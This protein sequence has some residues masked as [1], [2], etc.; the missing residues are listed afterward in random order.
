[1]NGNKTGMLIVSVLLPIIGMFL[2]INA[3]TSEGNVVAN[4]AKFLMFG[5]LIIG[6]IRPK[7]AIHLMI[8]ATGYLDL[9]KR[10]MIMDIT[11][12]FEDLYYVLGIAPCLMAGMIL[13]YLQKNMRS[14]VLS[15]GDLIRFVG[16][17]VVATVFAAMQLK[18]GVGGL[19]NAANA[20]AYI[21]C[22]YLIPCL[23]RDGLNLQRFIMYIIIVL[24]PVAIYGMYQS[25]FGLMKFEMDYLL[26][27][28]TLE[29]RQLDELIFRPFSTM[30][31]ASN[32]S[33]IC[34]VVCALCL[35]LS[36]D[37]FKSIPK[38]A[39][40]F[41]LACV[42]GYGAYITF[43]R[44]GW[45]CG[46]SAIVFYFAFKRKTTTVLLY[47]TGVS[48]MVALFF[49]AGYII[50]NKKLTEATESLLGDGG[51]ERNMAT[52]LGTFT[53]RL[54]TLDLTRTT[55]ERW[56]PFGV[57][58]EGVSPR[59]FEGSIYNDRTYYVH[60]GFSYVL[61]LVGYIP[62]SIMIIIGTYSLI[63]IHKGLL[64]ISQISDRKASTAMF[65]VGLGISVGFFANAAQIQT[66][67]VNFYLY[68]FFG[69][70]I[71]LTIASRTKQAT[72][73]STSVQATV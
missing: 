70:A 32:L 51:L 14:Y 46:I 22:I 39:V 55:P 6:L 45:I 13:H 37:Y 47:V 69:C 62:M 43:S 40:L 73:I 34:S 9:L 42:F 17:T 65:A 5:G 12:R 48:A 15:K 16:C 53:S 50:E 71:A 64:S 61:L 23:V 35:I 38:K 68:F 72:P 30:N 33:S 28:L 18:N 7:E 44:G 2:M 4:N 11:L 41:I 20:A 49:S 52:R 60:D 36:I 24:T 57:V 3:L 66:Y 63:K 27:G 8:I 54:D 59:E 29:V 25:W 10:I 58:V 67:P 31:A 26:S 21:Y 56:R 1:M 19:G